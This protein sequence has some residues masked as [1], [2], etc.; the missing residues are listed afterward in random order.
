M[1]RPLVLFLLAVCLT[2]VFGCRPTEVDKSTEENDRTNNYP[3][4][5]LSSI[6]LDKSEVNLKLGQSVQMQGTLVPEV[7]QSVIRIH[8]SSS[9]ES[10]FTVDDN[11]LITAVSEGFGCLTAEARYGSYT[12]KLL[13][14]HVYPPDEKIPNPEE[15]YRKWLGRWAIGGQAHRSS[16]TEADY[17]V[18]AYFYIDYVLSITELVPMESYRVIGWE[19]CERPPVQTFRD[20]GIQILTARFDK[21][22]GRFVF[23]R[24]RSQTSKVW[25]LS[26]YWSNYWS[27]DR[28]Y[29]SNYSNQENLPV[30]YARMDKG[31]HAIVHGA[32]NKVGNT[33]YYNVGMGLA[34]DGEYGTQT[35]NGPMLFPLQ[36]TR[37]DDIPLEKIGLSKTSLVMETGKERDL[38]FTWEPV[39]A[40]DFGQPEWS[41]SD[42]SV[43]SVEDG[44]LTALSVG[45]A[46]VTVTVGQ[47]RASCEVTVKKPYIHF[48]NKYFR[49]RI[50]EFWDVDGDGEISYE[51]AAAATHLNLR[52]EKVGVP[53]FVDYF[54]DLRYF[55]SVTEIPDRLLSN[56]NRVTVPANVVKIGNWALNGHDSRVILLG[57]PPAIGT[58]A[59]G[60]HYT[61]HTFPLTIW[62]PD[63]YYDEY[64]RETE[65]SGSNWSEY[66]NRIFKLSEHPAETP[67]PEYDD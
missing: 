60:E 41:S 17:G 12:Q 29:F 37:I 66:R 5:K 51:E 24:S 40:S 35:L 28:G 39:L 58:S 31:G 63:E 64:V 11:G 15:M 65:M 46:T 56:L 9:D 25:V 45:Q 59:F 19:M 4:V 16:L 57:P 47:F 26:P 38:T 10:V 23:V 44:H 53:F 14:V 61:S 32:F 6:Q 7:L 8:Y 22:T 55:T 67:V 1:K 30:A 43:V 62:V 3:D 49:D 54:D 18:G 50:C 2:F 27:N 36:M 48:Y 42:P 34:Y 33:T 21:D 13:P 20:A 52:R